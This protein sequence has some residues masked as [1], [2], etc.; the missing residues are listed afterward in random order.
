MPNR[1]K[2]DIGEQVVVGKKCPL[3]ILEE[4]RRNRKRTVVGTYYDKEAQ[5]LKYHLG[6]N[7]LSTIDF[8]GYGFRAEQLEEVVLGRLAGRPP[9]P[10][11]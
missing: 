9:Q 6:T 11:E 4:V 1:P 7:H 5:H 8:T 2:F 10:L 3:W